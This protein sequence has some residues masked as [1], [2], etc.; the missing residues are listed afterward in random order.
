MNSFGIFQTT[1]R[2]ALVVFSAGPLHD[3]LFYWMIEIDQFQKDLAVVQD[4]LSGSILSA[5][6]Y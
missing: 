5:E 4:Q 6:K 1:L 3:G 2:A